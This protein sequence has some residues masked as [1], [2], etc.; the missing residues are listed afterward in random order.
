MNSLDLSWSRHSTDESLTSESIGASYWVCHLCWWTQ[1][2]YP[3]LGAHQALS[4]QDRL[5]KHIHGEQGILYISTFPMH[6]SHIPSLT[7]AKLDPS[8][9]PS[10]LHSA[11]LAPLVQIPKAFQITWRPLWL[12]SAPPFLKQLSKMSSRPHWNRHILQTRKWSL[13][14]TPL[15]SYHCMV[16]GYSA[17]MAVWGSVGLAV[18]HVRVVTVV[19]CASSVSCARVVCHSSY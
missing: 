10:H 11:S 9:Y 14:T 15:C 2:V 18:S 19:C 8:N 12:K 5:E 16:S 7:D 6:R 1:Q 17:G 4:Q 3:W 13:A